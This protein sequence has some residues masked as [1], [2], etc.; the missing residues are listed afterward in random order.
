[1]IM[2]HKWNGTEREVSGN[3]RKGYLTAT[4]STISTSCGLESKPDL[5]GGKSTTA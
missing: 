1:M 5:R 2:E 3:G 4:F